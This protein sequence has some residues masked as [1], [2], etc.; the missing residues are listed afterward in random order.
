MIYLLT[1]TLQ[2]AIV[3]SLTCG[4]LEVRSSPYIALFYQW[5]QV[6][7][8]ANSMVRYETADYR[9]SSKSKIN[10][11]EQFVPDVQGNVRPCLPRANIFESG[12][13]ANWFSLSP[14]LN[15]QPVNSKKVLIR[16]FFSSMQ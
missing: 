15:Y 7:Y 1:A 14:D 2:C 3:I 13:G 10:N 8:D 11:Q 4:H 5:E 6:S 16:G 12:R 9:I